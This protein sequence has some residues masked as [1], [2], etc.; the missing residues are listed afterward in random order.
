MPDKLIG[1]AVRGSTISEVQTKISNLP[2]SRPRKKT[3]KSENLFVKLNKMEDQFWVSAQLDC[4]K[5][6]VLFKSSTRLKGRA[7]GYFGRF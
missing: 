4:R 7:Y 6:R 1:A 5:I 2:C 3:P